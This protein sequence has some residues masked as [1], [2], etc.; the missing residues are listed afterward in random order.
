MIDKRK[1][2]AV[3]WSMGAGRRMVRAIFFNQ[4]LLLTVSGALGGLILG[5]ALCW[6]QQ[7]FGLIRLG[8]SE[9]SFVVD[10]YPV[11]MVFTDFLLVLIT[12]TTI[13]GVASWL[14][15]LRLKEEGNRRFY[16]SR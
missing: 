16:L 12:V 6:A 15:T 1:D 8:A 14:P 10:A 13:G 11:R 9:G 4:G 2:M 7:Q 3:L 5:A